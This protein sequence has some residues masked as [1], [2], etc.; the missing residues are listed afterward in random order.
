MDAG[1]STKGLRV[2]GV[3]IGD[4]AWVAKFVAKKVEAV[5]LDVAKIDDVL[6]D[7]MIHYHMM[8][9]CQNTRP[10]FPARNTPTLLISDSLGSLDAVNLESMCTKGTGGTHADWTHELRSFAYMKLQVPHYRCG[11]GI[12]PC[13]GSAISSFYAL[14]DS[15]VRWLGHHGNAQQDL[16]NL[17]DVWAPGQDMSN[18]DSWTAPILSAL[19]CTHA[20]LLAEYA[21]TEWGPAA[22]PASSDAL[23]AIAGPTGTQNQNADGTGHSNPPSSQP[24]L[25]LPPL[26]MLFVSSQGEGR[27]HSN[28][29]AQQQAGDCPPADPSQRISTEHL[30]KCWK[31]HQYVLGHVVLARSEEYLKFWSVQ[32]IP[33][34]LKDERDTIF[35]EYLPETDT[36]D[37][38]APLSNPAAPDEKKKV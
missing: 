23:V 26:S 14:T 24:S 17:A 25:V 18:P 9:F 11:F 6:T 28:S 36:V 34:V 19:K 8:R 10:G 13:A 38:N 3:P 15:L 37:P 35:H 21:C 31:N 32:R 22:G 20:L 7:G 16:A 30:M 2:A 12:T 33:A 27:H 5:I 4:D 29:E 1:V